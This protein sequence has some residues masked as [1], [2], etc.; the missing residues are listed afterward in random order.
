M[1]DLILIAAVGLVGSGIGAPSCWSSLRDVD[2]LLSNGK[3]QRCKVRHAALDDAKEA[4]I[5]KSWCG[6]VTEDNGIRC[7]SLINKFELRAGKRQEKK[8]FSSWVLHRMPEGL[9]DL[10]LHRACNESRQRLQVEIDATHAAEREALRIRQ[11]A[12]LRATSG[13]ALAP[14]GRAVVAANSSLQSWELRL[15]EGGTVADACTNTVEKCGAGMGMKESVLLIIHMPW[16]QELTGAL[17]I[18]ALLHELG[19]GCQ[20]RA[21][22]IQM[23]VL[24]QPVELEVCRKLCA[25][26]CE[27]HAAEHHRAYQHLNIAP[28]A[29]GT[30]HILHSHADVALNLKELATVLRS[31]NATVAPRG[32]LLGVK[33]T[34]T[35]SRC[36]PLDQL[37]GS[38]QWFWH[39]DSRRECAAAQRE[40][41]GGVCCYG[42]VDLFMIPKSAQHAFAQAARTF[43]AVVA[44]VAVPT[45]FHELSVRQI[46]PQNSISCFGGCCTRVPWRQLSPLLPCVHRIDL[47]E[48]ATR[49]VPQRYKQHARQAAR[50]GCN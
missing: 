22:G 21:L 15:V 41:G 12:T 27:C 20:L 13:S 2:L 46:A 9:N 42:W 32:G 1:L 28:F 35:R 29:D 19:Y 3:Q 44:E 11:D 37:E 45:I 49:G 50:E 14:W 39:L 38:T 33:F 7:G 17:R 6:G 48:A 16:L 31:S 4:C 43:R 30:A 23:V 10:P 40:Y 5:S 47:Y 34:A 24:V 8:G 26:L 18:P 25:A 36:V